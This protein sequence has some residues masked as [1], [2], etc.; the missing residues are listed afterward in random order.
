MAGFVAL[1]TATGCLSAPVPAHERAEFGR[2]K[3][4]VKAPL[5][6]RLLVAVGSA[7]A[8]AGAAGAAAHPRIPPAARVAESLRA[9]A[10]FREVAVEPAGGVRPASLPPSTRAGEDRSLLLAISVRRSEV[11]YRGLSGL[12]PVSLLVWIFGGALDFWFP[13]ETY[14]ARVEWDL[15][16]VDPATGLPIA[17][18]RV[19]GRIEKDLNDWDRG[20]SVWDILLYSAAPASVERLAGVGEKLLPHAEAAA[21]L[22]LCRWLVE[23]ARPAL[24]K[25]PPPPPEPEAP[26][27]TR[28]LCVGV[29]SPRDD[30][31][32]AFADADA[33]DVAAALAGALG[34]EPADVTL[35]EDEAASREAVGA[36]LDARAAEK[37]GRRDR[38]YF[39][40][41]GR[42]GTD[43]GGEPQLLAWDSRA[44]DP[45][46]TGVPLRRVAE[47]LSGA[48][49]AT[50]L[51]DCAFQGR[52][53]ERGP[54]SDRA[55][56][57]AGL[58][59]PSRGGLRA[60]AAAY[61]VG[62]A[63]ARAGLKNG[64]FTDA[65]LEALAGAADADGDGTT[66]LGEAL[67]H[68]S[69]RVPAE[70]Q[71]RGVDERPALLAGDAGEPLWRR[72][73][74]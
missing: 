28:V 54:D 63:T 34:A 23:E 48:G 66:T 41:A 42:G 35:L 56:A 67:A 27:R 59:L 2:L 58:A 29:A 14:E 57:P 15:R 7:P 4:L 11:E 45:G 51:L 30:P 25:P 47:A 9:L 24:E 16:L 40:F 52:L 5:P 68:L 53:A 46:G 55:P 71:S 69:A 74:R 6:A 64:L 17:E 26:A 1:A 61:G 62:E 21:T 32:C 22:D 60:L 8:G 33:R 49:E 37:L 38:V 72:E 31:E 44:A 73:A 13:D 50:V 12:W 3:A 36:W 43:R 19:Q 10:L 65:L 18:G 39:F 20:F 70:A